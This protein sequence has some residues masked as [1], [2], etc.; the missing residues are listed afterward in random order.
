MDTHL[1]D[2]D[3]DPPFL[4]RSLL[5]TLAGEL[6]FGLQ[7]LAM[8]SIHTTT[9]QKRIQKIQN[10][11]KKERKKEISIPPT[12]RPPRLVARPLLQPL[13]Q[14]PSFASVAAPAFSAALAAAAGCRCLGAV[15][16]SVGAAGGLWRWV[17]GVLWG[18]GILVSRVELRLGVWWG[19]WGCGLCGGVCC[20]C[21]CWA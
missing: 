14:G 13:L 17:G 6:P 1:L 9:S 4:A 15:C 12:P 3:R 2:L 19:R 18:G 21:C 20:C 8:A 11:I 16:G 7:T 10:K 5:S